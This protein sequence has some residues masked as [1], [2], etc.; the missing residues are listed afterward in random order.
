M[1][2]FLKF[3]DCSDKTGSKIAQIITETL[4]SHAIPHADSRPQ[5]S[6]NAASISG[7]YNGAQAIINEQYPTAIF[8]PCGCHT[9]NLCVNDAD[10]CILKAITYCGTIQTI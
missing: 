4:K 6:D 1:Q 9:L 5:G 2:R 8:F 3:V 10:E 7:K